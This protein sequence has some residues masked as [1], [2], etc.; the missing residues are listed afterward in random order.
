M[1]KKCLE[2]KM[3]LIDELKLIMKEKNIS[4]A[5]AARY[6]RSSEMT[7]RRWLNRENIPSDLSQ[8]G[9]RQGI[10]RIKRLQTVLKK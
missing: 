2:E 3:D 8:E 7:I 9:I 6:V 4:T 5:G 10:Y 1:L